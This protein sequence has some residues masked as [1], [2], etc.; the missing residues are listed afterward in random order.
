MDSDLD[1]FWGK[2]VAVLAVPVGVSGYYLCNSRLHSVNLHY[3][4]Y[5]QVHFAAC[6]RYELFY[7]QHLKMLEECVL[8]NT[9][10]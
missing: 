2:T 10:K 1:N 9:I 3:T 4:L 8:E 5:Q 6:F 7:K